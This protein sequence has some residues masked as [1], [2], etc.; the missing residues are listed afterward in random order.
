MTAQELAKLYH[1]AC[2]KLQIEGVLP[3]E[4]GIL[5]KPW[6]FTHDRYKASST[7]IAEE[8]LKHINISEIPLEGDIRE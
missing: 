5:S 7:V 4:W 1:E 8:L 2:L 6:E 3:L